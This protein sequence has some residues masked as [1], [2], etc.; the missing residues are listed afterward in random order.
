MANPDFDRLIASTLQKYIPVLVDNVFTSK[1]LLF[2]IESFGQVETLDGGTSIVQPLMYAELNNQGSYSGAD[3][4]LT[5]E[6]EG[7]T[8]AEFDWR[9]YYATIKLKN[10]DIAKNSGAPAVLRI[11]ETEIRRAELSIAESLD[12]LFFLDGTGNANKDFLGLD[13]IV[14]AT[15]PL[16][17]I[18]PN[19]AGSEYWRSNVDSGSA[20]TDFSEIR[21]M[22]LACSEGNDYPT[23]IMTT[24][25]LYAGIDSMFEQRQRFQDPTFANQGFE[26]IMFHGAPI[27]FDRNCQ[28]GRIYF[29]NLDYIHM[30]K[31]GSRWF[32]MSDWLEPANQDVRIKK[33]VLNGQLGCSNRK[34]QGLLTGASITL[35]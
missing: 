14:S 16:G 25:S 35:P 10:M 13:A 21:Q 28:S 26:T 1:P 22:Y 9:G 8:A 2:A 15:T 5:D 11:V 3:V 29:L 27:S 24:E 17:G 32:E 20:M 33:I 18:N 19:V 23:N 34:R 7:T 6:D 12:R 31:L 4:F 30:Y